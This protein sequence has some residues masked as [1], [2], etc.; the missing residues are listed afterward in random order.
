MPTVTIRIED[1]IRRIELP[2]EVATAE[3]IK[4]GSGAYFVK[5][6]TGSREIF[7]DEHGT[8]SDGNSVDGFSVELLSVREALIRE[9]FAS[10]IVNGKSAGTGSLIVKSPMPGL[11]RSIL[12]AVGDTVEKNSTLLILEAMKMENNISAAGAGIVTSIFV[13]P[14]TSVDK[15]ARLIEI[16]RREP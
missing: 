1:D 15:N 7:V 14:G 4:M 11:V 6:A 8:F 10:S 3:V 9:R 5:T 12:V 2:E 13:E 16:E